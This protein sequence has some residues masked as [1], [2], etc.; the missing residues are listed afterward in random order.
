MKK[1]V[2]AGILGGFIFLFLILKGGILLYLAVAILIILGL[3]EYCRLV[4]A[5]GYR[6]Y[7][8]VIAGLS[9]LHLLLRM[10]LSSKYP[11]VLS[12]AVGLFLLFAVFASFLQTLNKDSTPKNLFLTTGINL[13]GLVYPGL[14]FSYI[15]LIREL[16]PPF[17]WKILLYSFLVIWGNDTGAYFIGS[18]IGKRPLAPTISPRKTREGAV[19]GVAIGTIVGVVYGVATDL[20][21]SLLLFTPIFG[22]IGQIGDLFESFLKRTAGVKDSGEFLPGHGGVLDRFDSALFVLPIVY[23]VVLFIGL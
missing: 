21:L 3:M 23:Y 16:P 18:A 5:V 1:R 4:E 15:I 20:P 2:I 8:L 7:F 9:V 13:F 17:G 10:V 11:I 6:V 12:D 14:L 22:L 19:G